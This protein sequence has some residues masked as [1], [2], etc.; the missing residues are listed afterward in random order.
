[1]KNIYRFITICLVVFLF[2]ASYT[3]VVI[4]QE[5]ES[6][7][8]QEE[9]YMFV[10]EGC[11]Y[12][13]VAEDFI[14]EHGLSQYVAILDVEADPKNAELYNTKFDEASVPLQDRGSTPVMFEGLSYFLGS[15]QIMYRLGERFGIETGIDPIENGDSEKSTTVIIIIFGIAL[16]ISV[17]FIFL[18]KKNEK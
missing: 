2:G 7:E 12:C 6:V 16:V 4:A 1:M 15:D 5:P 13:R 3:R 14:E 11:P 8:G 17:G 10:K 9:F 18:N